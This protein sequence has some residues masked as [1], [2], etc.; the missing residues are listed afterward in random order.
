MENT[1][2]LAQ[3]LG[4]VF[5]V[6][7]LGAMINSQ[8]MIY[9]IDEFSKSNSMRYL[10]GVM[11]MLAGLAL[12]LSHN[13]WQTDLAGFL[14]T[15]VGWAMVFEGALWTLFPQ[16]LTEIAGRFRSKSLMYVSGMIGILM[17]AYLVYFG[18]FA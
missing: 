8:G 5:V 3:L 6:S 17:G 15:F 16:Q 12:V 4:P 13:Y 18:Y 2:Y 9:L 10:V 7:S 1:I 14:I 11:E